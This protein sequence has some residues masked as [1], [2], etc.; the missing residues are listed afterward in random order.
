MLEEQ[1]REIK[2]FK[3]D[4]KNILLSLHS[5]DSSII[6]QKYVQDIQQQL[7]ETSKEASFFSDLSNINNLE[8]RNLLYAKMNVA[9]AA[10]IQISLEVK[11]SVM[12]P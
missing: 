4:F 8:L 3:H 10:Q 1:A 7:L 11:D 12:F 2:K 5:E 6:S 9:I